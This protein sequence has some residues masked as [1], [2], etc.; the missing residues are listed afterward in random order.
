MCVGLN[1]Y[2]GRTPKTKKVLNVYFH[3]RLLKQKKVLKR[4][5]WI[6]KAMM[7][8]WAQLARWSYSE[9]EWRRA[10]GKEG[11]PWQALAWLLGL[12]RSVCAPAYSPSSRPSA[13]PWLPE[14][15]PRPPGLASVGWKCQ[16]ALLVRG[17]P[18]Q[19]ASAREGC[20]V[21]AG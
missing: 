14:F 21:V 19:E 2:G 18:E 8:R 10:R 11:R 20:S 4:K 13:L 9:L 6:R 3:F 12:P 15:L 5:V 17:W 7:V 1:W 16:L